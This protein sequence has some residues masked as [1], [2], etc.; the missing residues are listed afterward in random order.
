M[1]HLIGGAMLLCA[2][3]ALGFG[4]AG[5]LKERVRE[6]EGLLL[7]LKTME[8]ELSGKRTPLPEL[9]QKVKNCSRGQITQLYLL[10]EEYLKESEGT[11]FSDLWKKAVDK[12][13]LHLNDREI[14]VLYEIG[15]VLGRYDSKSQCDALNAIQTRLT[16]F[17]EEANEHNSRMGRV[18]G[19]LG[20]ATG[21]LLMIIL[22]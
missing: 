21:A 15:N 13:E 11:A 16:S 3:T 8:L 7:S 20:V 10:C 2:S 5:V 22:I 12:A 1:I 17:L 9:I 6:L 19:T 18:Y 4:A 14:T